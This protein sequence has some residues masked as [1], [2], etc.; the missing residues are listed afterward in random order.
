MYST[1]NLPLI[2]LK[3]KDNS[4]KSGKSLRQEFY[5][6]LNYYCDIIYETLIYRRKCVE[7]VIYNKRMSDFLLQKDKDTDEPLWDIDRTT[8]TLGYCGLYECLQVL[9][10]EYGEAILN[11]INSKKEQYN[12]ED[13]LR[14]SV[15]GSP[16]EAASHRFA[17]IIKEKY[18]DFELAGIQGKHYLTNSSHI[19]VSEKTDRIDHIKKAAKYHL[20]SLGGNILHIWSGE[21]WSDPEAIWSLNKKILETGTIFWAYSKVFTYCPEC[22]Y[23]IN[24]EL[25]KCP[26]CGSKHLYVYDRITG[27]YLCI[28]TFNDGKVQEFKDRYRHKV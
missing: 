17:E 8:I 4:E 12:I 13:G 14:W 9:E 24:D 22:G 19:P 7:E 26:I 27:Y 18:P 10:D 1:L 11:F 23:T 3:A 2:A 28:E 16:A 21:V 25:K 15:I 20:L 5:N 6:L